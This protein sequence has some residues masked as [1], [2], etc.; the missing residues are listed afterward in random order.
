MRFFFF[1]I[2]HQRKPGEIPHAPVCLTICSAAPVLCFWDATVSRIWREEGEAGRAAIYQHTA[3]TGIPTNLRFL[4]TQL[5]PGSGP[6]NFNSP[7]VT[8]EASLP[9][10]F[11]RTI[12]ANPVSPPDAVY[13]LFEEH[14]TS[15][16]PCAPHSESTSVA[17]LRGARDWLGNTRRFRSRGRRI[18]TH[19]WEYAC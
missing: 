3:G 11:L 7:L 16:A 6:P 9:S 8:A 12:A 2:L 14:Q 1:I 15:L 13:N 18:S 10:S 17:A 19:F 4:L 5:S